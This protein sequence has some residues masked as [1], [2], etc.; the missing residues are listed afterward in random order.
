MELRKYQE[1]LST[2]ANKIL[3][4]NGMVY[5]A[6]EVRT[7]KTLTSLAT[8]QK[9]R[10]LKVLFVTKKKAMDSIRSD[11]DKF[12]FNFDLTVI[13]TESIHK[14]SGNFDVVISDEHHKYGA[15]PKMGRHA[16]TFK[17]MF[18]R[19]PLIMLSGTPTPETYSQIYHQLAVS[20]FTPFKAYKSFY[21]W[22]KEFV[23]IRQRKLPHGT[24]NDYSRAN[25]DAIKPYFEPIM[26]TFTQ[27]QAGFNTKIE[28]EL[29]FCDMKKSTYNLAEVLKKDLVV[30]AGRPDQIIADTAV[31]LLQKLHQIYSGTVRLDDGRR[32][33]FD[34]SKA[35][36]IKENFKGKKLAIF[37]KYKAELEALREVFG[38]LITDDLS[39]F[40]EHKPKHI[41]LQYVS[42]RE[43]VKLSEA[44]CIV[45]YNMDYSATSY[46]QARDR[47]T[48][49]ERKTN[50]VYY[51]FANK[52]IEMR[53]WMAVKN[54][55]SYTTQHFKKDYGSKV[56][57]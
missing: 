46:W 3:K 53:I 11:Y 32:I 24:I 29:L 54:K 36:F 15:F 13:N 28:S 48:T 9:F 51:L 5:L 22:A 4:E 7:G 20:D 37:Y 31:K 39:D 30:Y 17:S 27:E 55:K 45:F 52:G 44:D 26:L 40:N 41:A 2:Q 23:D 6:M 16:K 42:G 14:V 33:V 49:M 50:K 19:T 38:S 35:E 47:M 10:A 34:T 43:G 8:A 57:R 56:P 12:G 21:K 18:S 1:D 25:Y